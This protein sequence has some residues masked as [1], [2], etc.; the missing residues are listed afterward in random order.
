M[1]KKE[2]E[3]K[4]KRPTTLVSNQ[5]LFLLPLMS[6]VHVESKFSMMDA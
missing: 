5:N 3:K 1:A 2:E 4:K 6:V